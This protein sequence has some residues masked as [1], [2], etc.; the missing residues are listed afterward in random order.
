MGDNIEA[1]RLRAQRDRAWLTLM[2]IEDH[3]IDGETDPMVL[4][5]HLAAGHGLGDI[6]E[7]N[8]LH[9]RRVRKSRR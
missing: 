7:W 9:Q 5:F 8:A 2:A 4:G 1:D 6:D 3:V